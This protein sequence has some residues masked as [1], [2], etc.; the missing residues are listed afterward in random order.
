MIDIGIPKIHQ[1]NECWSEISPFLEKGI[2]YSNGEL[3]IDSILEKI[4][5]SQI[6]LIT[7]FEDGKLIAVV[8][9]EQCTFD[10]G[11]RI[12]NIQL[13]GGENLDQWFEQIEQIAYGFA[14]QYDCSEVYIVGRKGWAKKL[15]SVGY[16]V[17]HTVLH[18]EVK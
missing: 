12:L 11:K 6:I 3:S 15:K 7:I 1:I 16:S 17:L 5:S 10:T 2:E 14:K 13:A 8:S 4:N 9:L 18:K